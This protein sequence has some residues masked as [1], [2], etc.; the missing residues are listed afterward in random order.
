MGAL[1]QRRDWGRN[2]PEGRFLAA[3]HDAA[4]RVFS[5]VLGPDYNRLHRD[6]FHLDLGPYRACR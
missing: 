1:D 4:C 3:A 2:T 5:A 6:H